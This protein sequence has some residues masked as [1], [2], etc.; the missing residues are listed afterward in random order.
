MSGPMGMVHQGGHQM[1][2]MAPMFVPG[3]PYNMPGMQ[4]MQGMQYGYAPNMQGAPYGMQAQPHMAAGHQQGV[5]P[6][7][8]GPNPQQQH[9]QQQQQQ[10]PAQAAQRARTPL[11]ITNPETGKAVDLSSGQA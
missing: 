9:Q 10:R 5:P 6:P 2:N 3:M 8:M 7:Q 1:S 11:K 4:N